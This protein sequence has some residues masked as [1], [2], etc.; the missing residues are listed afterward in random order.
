MDGTC[1]CV[2]ARLDND[3]VCAGCGGWRDLSRE[4]FEHL[5]D[6]IAGSIESDPR[7]RVRRVRGRKR[8]IDGRLNVS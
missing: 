7:Q 4:E 1:T 8:P 2:N 6:V 3:G 5:T